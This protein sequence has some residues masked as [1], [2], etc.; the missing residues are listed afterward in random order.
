MEELPPPAEDPPPRVV[1]VPSEHPPPADNRHTFGQEQNAPK[2]ESPIRK[3]LRRMSLALGREQAL[4]LE[5]PPPMRDL[6]ENMVTSSGHDWR[7]GPI[8]MSERRRVFSMN[9]RHRASTITGQTTSPFIGVD[10]NLL[11]LVHFLRY[12]RSER[13]QPGRNIPGFV[14]A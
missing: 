11:A 4:P 3:Y 10:C 6:P 2:Q 14:A 9:A 8:N 5:L 12:V 1:S 13:E 7:A